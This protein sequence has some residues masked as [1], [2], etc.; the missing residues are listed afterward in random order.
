MSLYTL[1]K[2]VTLPNGAIL[3]HGRT[4]A[5][6]NAETETITTFGLPYTRAR[7]EGEP[8]SSL[9]IDDGEWILLAW[10]DG[11]NNVDFIKLDGGIGMVLFYHDRVEVVQ[12]D[13]NP[14]MG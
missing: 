7:V 10:D 8:T 14:A 5:W 3:S 6:W 13:V 4:L 12:K 9:P 1:V 2:T 11:R